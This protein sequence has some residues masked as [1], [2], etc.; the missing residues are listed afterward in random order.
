MT[1]DTQNL[2]MA[3]RLHLLTETGPGTRM[4]TLLRRFWQPVALLGSVEPGAARALRILGEDL[5]L[6]RGAGGTPHLVGGRCAH[7]RTLLHTGWVEGERIRC[8]YH[9]WCYDGTGQCTEMPAEKDTLPATVK[10]AGYPLHDYCGILFA[11]MGE[12]EAPAFELPRKDVFEDPDR[13]IFVREQTWPCHWLQQ[14][15][16]SLDATHV[17][18]VHQ[19]GVVGTFGEAVTPIIPTLE[20]IETVSGIRQIATRSKDNVRASDWTFPNNNHI[21]VPGVA[22][23]FP[24]MEIGVWMVAVDDTHTSRLQIYSCPS[25]SDESDARLA[26]H[27]H[28]Y[29]GYNP[30]DHHH[31]LM[32]EGKYPTELG[33]ELVGAQDYVAAVGQGPVADR[34]NERLGKSDEGIVML[35][36]VL[37]REMDAIANGAPTKQWHKL[38]ESVELLLPG[39]TA[40]EA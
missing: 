36:R 21:L 4:G 32:V 26:A 10:I 2:P 16:N 13:I 22:R 19:M 31:E 6:Y 14:V 3:E 11:Y 40:A 18:F 25:V 28:K 15:E 9:G 35:R 29:A 17:S 1:Q 8:M 27:F 33:F 12:G 30:T 37:W 7:R 5:T 23:E 39:Q 24:W 38:D 34:L 20:Y